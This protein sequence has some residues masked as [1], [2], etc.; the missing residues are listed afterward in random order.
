LDLLGELLEYSQ[1][2]AVQ[3]R[4]GMEPMVLEEQ[5]VAAMVTDMVI[6]MEQLEQGTQAEAVV[7][8]TMVVQE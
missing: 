1:G 4:H 7:L 3:N 5:V 2:A 6:M 8:D